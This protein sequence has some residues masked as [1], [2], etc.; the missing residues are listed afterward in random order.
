MPTTSRQAT[1]YVGLLQAQIGH[2]HKAVAYKYGPTGKKSRLEHAAPTGNE[3]IK[4][5]DVVNRELGEAWTIES[6]TVWIH[7]YG[8]A[9]E[10]PVGIGG[11][12]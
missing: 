7:G 1:R 8:V 11:S 10:L 12:A 2:A 4:G 3:R 5:L 9:N 6:S